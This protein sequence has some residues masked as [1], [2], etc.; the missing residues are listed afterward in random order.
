[1]NYNE[2]LAEIEVDTNEL[3]QDLDKSAIESDKA[4]SELLTAIDVSF[5]N[6]THSIADNSPQLPKKIQYRYGKKNEI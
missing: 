4:L 3:L 6:F 1:M 2:L 5:I